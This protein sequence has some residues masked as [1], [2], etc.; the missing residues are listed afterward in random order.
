VNSGNFEAI[1]RS[2]FPPGATQQSASSIGNAFQLVGISD[3]SFDELK[4]FYAQ[5]IPAS[6]A[7]ETGRFEVEGTLTIA[8]ANPDGGI[9]IVPAND[10][11]QYLVTISVG[12]ST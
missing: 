6:G 7:T 8:L 3:M 11:G 10:Q 9:L 4:S 5:Q 12:T 1:A 2:L